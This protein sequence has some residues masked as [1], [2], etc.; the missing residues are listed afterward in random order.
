MDDA[1][2]TLAEFD[3]GLGDGPALY[4]GG[5]SSLAG[6]LAANHIA[7]WACR[8]SELFEDRIE[9]PLPPVK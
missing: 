5:R 8:P 9:V 2:A 6:G 3:D 7:K 1:V 4:A